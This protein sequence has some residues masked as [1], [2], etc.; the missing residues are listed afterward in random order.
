MAITKSL[1]KL[2]IWYSHV[3]QTLILPESVKVN[4]YENNDTAKL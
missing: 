2:T 1:F 3:S 4:N